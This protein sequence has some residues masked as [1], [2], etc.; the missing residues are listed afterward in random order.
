MLGSEQVC[1]DF[2]FRKHKSDIISLI[3]FAPQLDQ[4]ILYR[5]VYPREQCDVISEF[6]TTAYFFIRYLEGPVVPISK[7][8]VPIIWY[9]VRHP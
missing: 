2:V 4:I 7:A 1:Q 5:C 6:S 9:L 8:H 3:L